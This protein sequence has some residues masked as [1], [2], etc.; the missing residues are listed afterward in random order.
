LKDV[1]AES[2]S[3]V[4]M[5]YPSIQCMIHQRIAHELHSMGVPGNVTRK[6]T[7]MAHTLTGIDIHPATQIGHHFFIDHGTGVVIGATAVIGNHVSIYQG[8]T[9]GAKSFSVDSVT[10]MRIKGVPR[11]PIIEDHVTIYS[12]AVVLGRVRIGKG[13]VIGGNTWVTTDVAP[14]A[15]IVQ[16]KSKVGSNKDQ[17]FQRHVDGHGI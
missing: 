12:N 1:A 5:S 7:E 17:L 9:L 16:V 10:G 8:V 6:L 2:M 4:V 11:H 13:A 3:E 14:N 15:V